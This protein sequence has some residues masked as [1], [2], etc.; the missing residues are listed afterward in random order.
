MNHYDGMR[1]TTA[2]RQTVG[3]TWL[4]RLVCTDWVGIQD[5]E[6]PRVWISD[7]AAS[8]IKMGIGEDKKL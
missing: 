2:S 8:V 4:D 6:I 3:G 1:S 7:E 5:R